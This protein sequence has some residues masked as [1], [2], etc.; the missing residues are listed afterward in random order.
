MVAQGSTYAIIGAI[1]HDYSGGKRLFEAAFDAVDE[2]GHSVLDP[3]HII[4]AVFMDDEAPLR[5]TQEIERYGITLEM[6][7]T[8]LAL[9]EPVDLSFQPAMLVGERQS[10]GA[11]AA[12][13]YKNVRLRFELHIKTVADTLEYYGTG[14]SHWDFYMAQLQVALES[15]ATSIKRLH[16]LALQSRS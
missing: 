2:C 13:L 15:D 8:V 5:A 10:V 11:E 9:V 14:V 7:E 12:T 1:K 4:F 3:I 16:T 6:V